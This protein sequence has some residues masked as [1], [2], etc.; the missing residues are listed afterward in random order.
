[1]SLYSQYAD[2]PPIEA[3]MATLRPTV[4][5]FT[6]VYIVLNALDEGP[7]RPELLTLLRYPQVDVDGLDVLGDE[8][9]TARH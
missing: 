7:E 8:S 4:G 3:L 5:T 1:M 9:K 6:H 2:T